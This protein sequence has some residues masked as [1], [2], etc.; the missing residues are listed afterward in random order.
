MTGWTDDSESLTVNNTEV[1]RFAGSVYTSSSMNIP[2]PAL[3]PTI[4]AS[5]VDNQT[6]SL[7]VKSNG[8]PLLNAALI[9]V[10]LCVHC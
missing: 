9:Q 2:P 10:A 5:A 1:H 3:L 8:A 7:V 6:P 4:T